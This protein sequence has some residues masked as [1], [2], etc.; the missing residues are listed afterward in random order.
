VMFFMMSDVAK[1]SSWVDPPPCFLRARSSK[2]YNHSST[3]SLKHDH[4]NRTEI[5][6]RFASAASAFTHERIRRLASMIWPCVLRLFTNATSSRALRDHHSLRELLA[7]SLYGAH[8]RLTNT[9]LCT[10]TGTNPHDHAAR[11]AL[12]SCWAPKIRML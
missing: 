1:R 4:C 2:T 3:A 6:T 12:D 9:W 11:F 8:S 7:R 10:T 5:F